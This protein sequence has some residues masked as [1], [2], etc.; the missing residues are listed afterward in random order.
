MDL[1]KLAQ[2]NTEILLE[3]LQPIG[4]VCFNQDFLS[5]AIIYETVAG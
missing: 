5:S 3:L 1:Q 4:H 2:E